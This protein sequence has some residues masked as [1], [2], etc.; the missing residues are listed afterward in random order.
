MINYMYFLLSSF[1][2]DIDECDRNMFTC[3]AYAGCVNS[4]GSYNCQCDNGFSGDGSTN[5]TGE[6]KYS[7]N[8][9]HSYLTKDFF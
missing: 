6:Y 3:P 8:I 9:M 7:Y 1:L 4:H 2:P 5:C